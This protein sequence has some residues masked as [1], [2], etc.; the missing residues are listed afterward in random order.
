MAC[1][2]FTVCVRNKGALH[3]TCSFLQINIRNH[4]PETVQNSCLPKCMCVCMHEHVC[5]CMNM[6]VHM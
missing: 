5:A 1:L 6:C 3:I 4:T 2:I